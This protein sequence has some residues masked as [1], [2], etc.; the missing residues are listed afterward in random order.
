MDKDRAIFF[1]DARNI[2]G[3]GRNYGVS[4]I[5]YK[6]LV[7]VLARRYKI[8]R[9]YYYDGA[10][11][12]KERTV[13]KERFFESL[14]QAGITLRLKEIDFAR[15][16]PSQKGIDIYLTTDMISLAFENAYDVAV[17][18]SGD[19]DYVALIDLVKSK[20]KKVVVM[21]F[22]SCLSQGLR[23]VADEVIALENY[24]DVLLRRNETPPLSPGQDK[25][26]TAERLNKKL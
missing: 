25:I 20:G 7:E 10:P 22:S 21:S 11:H 6:N 2:I 1:I 8:I 26:R 4:R 12:K 3:G 16:N 14:R 24:P 9:G 13:E 15:P 17:L 18:L 23:E 5:I 19:G